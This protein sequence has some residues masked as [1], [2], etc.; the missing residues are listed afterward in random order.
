[1]TGPSS[2]TNGVASTNFTIGANGTITGTVIVT[3]SDSSGGGTFTP[4]TVSISSGTPTATFTYTPGSTGVKT[5]SVTNNGGLTNPSN[6][7]YTSN[8]GPTV[9]QPTNANWYFSHNNWN[10]TSGSAIAVSGGAYFK[11]G[12]SGTSIAVGLDL[13]SL[14]S[15]GETSDQYPSIRYTVDGGAYIDS[16]LTIGQTSLSITGLSAGNHTIEL[17][18]L[19]GHWDNSPATAKDRWNTPLYCLKITGA[20]L[21][22][23]AASVAQTLKPYKL[24][25]YGDS[26]SE[27]VRANNSTTHPAAHNAY[28]T[29]PAFVAEGL[30]A[31]LGNHSFA[32]SNWNAAGTGNAPGLLAGYA[33]IYN[34]VSRLTTGQYT[35][36]PDYVAIMHGANGSPAASDVTT[37]IG[38]IRTAA[39]NAYIFVIIPVG[40]QGRSNI[41]TGVTNYLTA[42]LTEHKVKIIDVG[43]TLNT[44]LTA[45]GSATV[46]AID[47]LHPRIS[48]NARLASAI[49]KQIRQYLPSDVQGSTTKATA[50]ITL[51]NTSGSNQ[52]NLTSLKWAWYDSI[53]PDLHSVPVESGLTETTDA[54]GSLVIPLKNTQLV[55]GQTGWLTVTDSNGNPATAYK[56]FSGPVTVA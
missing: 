3:P 4:T 52:I 6:I 34:G 24:L 27:G 56:A 23:S 12:F 16:Q 8:A 22:A 38:N 11:L 40:G 2:G 42:N 15:A 50:T 49:I 35:V 53:T 55:A 33:S 17:W 19:A 10:V 21:D 9:L 41:T 43:T 31:E 20:T 30:N 36:Q 46:K 26:I 39:P 47:G 54:S 7:S 28:E 44:G 37:V 14:A 18:Y 32:G 45:I 5:I 29:I 13:S 48:W 51:V 25:W 1:M